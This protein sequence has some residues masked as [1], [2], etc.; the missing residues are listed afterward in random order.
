MDDRGID[1]LVDVRSVPYGRFNPAFNRPALQRAFGERYLW[2]G[3][4]LGGKPGPATDEGMNWLI[5]QHER[6]VV[7]IV[8][9]VEWDPRKCHRLTDIAVRLLEEG[10]DAVHL[11]H[12]GT[13]H[14]TQ[15]YYVKK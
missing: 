5:A 9:C 8:M 3:D 12:D 15:H 4:I 7:L 11:L 13:E 10:I 2:K 1:L 14:T 6:G